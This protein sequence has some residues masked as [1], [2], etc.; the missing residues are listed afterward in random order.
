MAT[1]AII[2]STN[3]SDNSGS[4]PGLLIA[5]STFF[6]VLVVFSCIRCFINKKNIDNLADQLNKI[7]DFLSNLEKLKPMR[8]SSEQLII[9]TEDFAHMLGAGGCGTVY[10]GSFPNSATVAVKVLRGSSDQQIEA[11]FMAEV[12]TIGRIH[13]FNLVRLI[14]F[15]FENSMQALVY[16][17]M[18]NGSLDGFLF[19]N[20]E[21]I[22]FDKLHE[23]ALGTAKGIA[24][25]HEECQQRIIHYDI[26]PGNIL[27][28]Q[29][30]S[31]KVADFGLAKLC[32]R[33]ATHVTMT[34]GRGRGTPGYAA[35][36]LWMPFPVTYKCDVYSYGM[37]L[38]EIV[39]RRR[40]LEFNLPESQEWFPKWVQEKFKKKEI[41]EI[42][43]ICEIEE[44]NGERAERMVKCSENARRRG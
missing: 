12:S 7:D 35:P 38:F 20:K 28:D 34:G 43:K 17:F 9:A 31:P 29:N 23:I 5:L 15:C 24:Y 14:G 37:L 19:R 21:R 26:K 41:D 18:E 42:A 33:D 4:G 10:K 30:L 25:L 39:G 2:S 40:N 13:H 32:N 22:P 36:E 3:T 6:G 8:F 1:P 27:L 16:E 44:D 11:Q